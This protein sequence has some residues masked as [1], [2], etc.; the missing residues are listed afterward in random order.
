MRTGRTPIRVTSV[1]ATFDT[2]M[3]VSVI[4]RNASP[5]SIGENSRTCWR[6]SVSRKNSENATAATS[7]AVAFATASERSRKMRSGSSGIRVRSSTTRNAP[8]RISD[9]TRS[10]TV[11]SVSQPSSAA[12]V[13]A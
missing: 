7:T 3:I 12:R 13:I 11:E 4:G 1:W 6:Y 5:V 10:P 8:S 2:T 9:A